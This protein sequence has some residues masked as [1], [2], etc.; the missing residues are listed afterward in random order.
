MSGAIKVLENESFLD[1][2]KIFEIASEK[3][4]ILP[5]WYRKAVAE[6]GY[7]Q[8]RALVHF[9]WDNAVNNVLNQT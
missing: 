9:Q 8:R 3:C 1:R 7:N 6:K 2:C 4:K 5:D